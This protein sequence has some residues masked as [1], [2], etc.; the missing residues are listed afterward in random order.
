MKKQNLIILVLCITALSALLTSCDS[1]APLEYTDVYSQT[2][3]K[4]IQVSEWQIV[5]YGHWYKRIN[6]S[7]IT[8]EICDYGMV[9]VYYKNSYNNWVPLPYS[10]TMYNAN[11]EL[12]TEEIWC[13]YALGTVDIDYVYNNP[14]DVSPRN[15][16]IKIVVLKL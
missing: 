11:G 8:T 4:T 15:L 13:G 16:D 7:T 14:L 5:E 6:I 10:T 2:Y 9:L 1:D 12:Y 3:F